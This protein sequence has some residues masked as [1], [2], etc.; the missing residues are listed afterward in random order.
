MPTSDYKQCSIEEV[1]GR[2][3][4]IYRKI[5]SLTK[6]IE[7]KG[8]MIKKVDYVRIK[9]N[10]HKKNKD[11]ITGGNHPVSAL[12]SIGKDKYNKKDNKHISAIYHKFVINAFNNMNILP[13][14]V[15]YVFHIEDAN[16]NILIP[17]TSELHATYNNNDSV[18][19]ISIDMP[20]Y[21][22][23]YSSGAD[24]NKTIL[25][26]IDITYSDITMRFDKMI[27]GYIKK[28][29]QVKIFTNKH[30]KSTKYMFLFETHMVYVDIC[31]YDK[32]IINIDI[33]YVI[34]VEWIE[35]FNNKIETEIDIGNKWDVIYDYKYEQTRLEALLDSHYGNRRKTSSFTP[36]TVELT[37][38]IF[39][40]AHKEEYTTQQ[41][42]NLLK[43]FTFRKS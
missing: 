33:H 20:T 23:A 10:K 1:L 40:Q 37:N 25:N 6:Y 38:K 22:E 34:R 24:N 42:G 3:R 30:I 28:R 21:N 4:R 43:S 36:L 7:D 29:E 39:D 26:C 41:L 31:I 19:R 35:L 16:R 11:I 2:K 27:K 18:T 14:S 13:D 32:Y 12:H 15:T 5:G 17:A 9:G 8:I